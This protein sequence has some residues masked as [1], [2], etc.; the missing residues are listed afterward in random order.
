P[1][2]GDPVAPLASHPDVVLATGDRLGRRRALRAAGRAPDHVGATRLGG[3]LDTQRTAWLL[4]GRQDDSTR[5]VAEQDAGAAIAVVEEPG[6]QLG[7]DDEDVLR[8]PGH[9]VRLGRGEGVDKA[10]AGGG[11]VER[12]GLRVADGLDRKST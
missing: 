10:R 7:P 8:K 9:D 11:D 12:A 6:E 2:R 1:P 4:A 3:H 5:A